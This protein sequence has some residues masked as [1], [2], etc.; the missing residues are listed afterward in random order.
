LFASSVLTASPVL[1]AGYLPPTRYPAVRVPKP[2]QYGSAERSLIALQERAAALARGGANADLEQLRAMHEQLT[3]HVPR[4]WLLRWN[5]L[6]ALITLG[7]GDSD[8]A[9]A[10]ERELEQLELDFSHREPIATGLAHLRARPRP[11]ASGPDSA[12]TRQSGASRR[13]R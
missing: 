6:E 13:T 2:R 10:L 1:P 11:A 5:L 3:A 8:L 4:E 9:R 12:D 7:A